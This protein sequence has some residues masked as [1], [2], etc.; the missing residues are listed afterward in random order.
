MN[1]DFLI[2]IHDY[3][4]EE[5]GWMDIE[6]FIETKGLQYIDEYFDIETDFISNIQNFNNFFSK[7]RYFDSLIAKIEVYEYDSAYNFY[8]LD[9]NYKKLKELS[10]CSFS[11][12]SDY[13]KEFIYRCQ[14]RGMCSFWF[15][16]VSSMSYMK[17]A[18]DAFFL[19]VHLSPKID[20]KSIFRKKSNVLYY[21]DKD[22]LNTD[23]DYIYPKNCGEKILL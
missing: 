13:N 16:D 15:I 8:R 2:T 4:S 5:R 20:F 1:N 18:M 19:H 3:E 9:G 22:T 23:E 17:N 12:I 6:D 14:C 10:E 21:Y 11:Y 7:N